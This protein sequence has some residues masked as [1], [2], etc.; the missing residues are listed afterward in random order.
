MQMIC[1]SVAL[2][3][4]KKKIIIIIMST[5]SIA[6]L[7]ALAEGGHKVSKDKL[8]FCQQSVEY[9]GRQLSG[10]KKCIAPSQIEA[11]S[12]ASQP[13]TV[14]QML[15]FLGMTGYSRPWICDYAIKIAPQL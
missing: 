7:I 5:D 1:L 6:V 2:Q 15:S 10:D 3:K 12:K 14:G 8:Q 11:I 13:Q 9:L 4:K